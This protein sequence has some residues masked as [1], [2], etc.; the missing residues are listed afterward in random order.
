MYY[1]GPLWRI[2]KFQWMKLPCRWNRT[3][4]LYAPKLF[5]SFL[6]LPI[7]SQFQLPSN[8]ATDYRYPLP[9][10]DRFI[11]YF[12]VTDPQKLRLLVKVRK[13]KLMHSG[14][15]YSSFLCKIQMQLNGLMGHFNWSV[16]EYEVC[17]LWNLE[18][19]V[20]FCLSTTYYHV[21]VAHQIHLWIHALLSENTRLQNFFLQTINIV[22]DYK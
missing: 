11:R 10:I 17:M 15:N 3:N 16:V 14:T 19:H 8:K 13:V 9:N 20:C 22:N 1:F 18:V 5:S 21:L 6:Y 2:K 7:I 12:T 4:Q